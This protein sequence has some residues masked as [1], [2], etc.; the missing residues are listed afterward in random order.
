[1]G[2]LYRVRYR[3][4]NEVGFSDYSDV[5]YIVAA[6][7]PYMPTAP[8][9]EIVGDELHISWNVPYYAGSHITE[10]EIVFAND[11]GDSYNTHVDC[12]GSSVSIFDARAC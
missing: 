10:A 12:D 9:A 3:A 2:Q 11:A 6:D 7:I 4:N 8:S 1:M 5:A